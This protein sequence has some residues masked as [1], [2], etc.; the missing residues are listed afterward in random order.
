MC[1]IYYK[2]SPN[3]THCTRT[4]DRCRGH[5][6]IEEE[7]EINKHVYNRIVCLSQSTN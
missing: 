3:Y 1:F 4:M 5:I 2:R 6:G 7:P